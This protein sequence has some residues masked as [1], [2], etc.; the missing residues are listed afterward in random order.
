MS[1]STVTR[2]RDSK[3]RGL[4]KHARRQRE[5]RYLQT[6]LHY[7]TTAA[8]TNCE[9][10]R[11]AQQSVNNHHPSMQSFTDRREMFEVVCC[12]DQ[13]LIL[14]SSLDISIYA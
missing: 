2:Q 6:L 3:V 14:S 9:A 11:K 8:W 12:E 10:T 4:W 1:L 13:V 5:V 7:R